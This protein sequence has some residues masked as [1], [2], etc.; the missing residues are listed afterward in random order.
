MNYL[1][2]T[3]GNSIWLIG[4]FVVF[5]TLCGLFLILSKR[6][7]SDIFILMML[8]ILLLVFNYFTPRAEDAARYS[9]AWAP[10]I[11]LVAGKWFSEIYEFI[12]KYQK[13]IAL[14]VFVFVIVLSYINLREKLDIMAK[15]KQFSPAFFEA[16][17]WIKE[18]T[19]KNAVISTFWSSRAIYNCQ[20]NSPGAPADLRLSNDVNY[21]LSV[22]KE[23][24]IT[25]IFIQ[26]FSIDTQ[27]KHLRES[28]DLDFV[29][30][31]ENNPKYFKKV[32]E[33]GPSLQQCLQQ[34]G[35]D[36]NIVY[37]INYTAVSR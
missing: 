25:H 30:L 15:V 6:E 36:G 8:F 29:N 24:G 32:Y 23:F 5:A 19:P 3:Y 4:N 14:I 20:R 17:N 13:Y 10:F 37:E 22:A 16:C 7:R 9:L 33:N 18:N 28:F 35:C 26:K 31:L 1:N 27:N 34:G 12:K 21:T 11:A 2:F